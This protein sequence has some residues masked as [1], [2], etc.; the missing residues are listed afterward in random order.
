MRGWPVM[1][2][3]LYVGMSEDRPAGWDFFVSYTQADRTWAEWIAWVLEEDGHKV[4]VQAWDFVPGSN[5]IQGM[6]AGAAKAARTIA[7]L[8]PA[9]LESEYGTAEW[10][11]AWA[12]DPAGAQRKLLVTRVKDCDRPGLLAG[13]VGVDLF[14]MTEAEAR[15][16]LRTMVSSAVTGRA[17]PE[18]APVFPGRAMP[19]EPRFPGALPRVWKVP[20]RNPNFTGRAEDLAALARSLASGSTVTVQSLRGMGGVGKTQLATEFAYAHAGDYDLVYWIAAEE[21]ATIPDQFTALARQLGLD[22][23]PD[24]EILQA[25][26]MTGCA[27]FPAGCW[28]SITPMR[29]LTSGPG[30]RAVRCR[31][32]SPGT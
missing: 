10:Q 15:A 29:P 28:S 22:P 23:V 9:Y 21:P 31:P 17:K 6:Q 19:R 27:A 3:R 26:S 4:L 25:R 1:W 13:V 12:S 2:D 11:A 30:F 8:S 32:E 18:V 20:A 16:R 14:G 24:P 5:W 7:V